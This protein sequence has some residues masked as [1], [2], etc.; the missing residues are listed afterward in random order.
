MRSS[1]VSVPEGIDLA[2]LAGY[3]RVEAA[4]GRLSRRI[5]P[6]LA[7]VT[8]EDANPYLSYAVPDDGARPEPDD[9]AALTGWFAANASRAS[10][11]TSVDSQ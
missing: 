5:G 8:V 7:T 6:F 10:R 2:G 9:V 11:A 1:E 4:A 3:I